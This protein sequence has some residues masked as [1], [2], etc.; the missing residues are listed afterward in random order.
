MAGPGMLHL[1]FREPE[2]SAV[3]AAR[4]DAHMRCLGGGIVGLITRGW[5]IRYMS[6][7][8][9]STEGSG[10]GTAAGPPACSQSPQQERQPGGPPSNTPGLDCS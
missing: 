6:F 10:G 4:A 1:A 7:T 8:I 5:N 9:A 3:L 2:S